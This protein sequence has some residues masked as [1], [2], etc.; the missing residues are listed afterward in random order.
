MASLS[1]EAWS[2]LLTISV[3]ASGP[4]WIGPGQGCQRIFAQNILLMPAFAAFYV[5]RGILVARV[6]SRFINISFHM[7]SATVPCRRA[8]A[9]K[10]ED[11][12]PV[13]LR[14]EREV[15]AAAA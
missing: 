12:S 6:T 7:D 1:G 2:G 4:V 15:K 9:A 8:A 10:L 13:W 3:T 14:L 5:Q 11:S